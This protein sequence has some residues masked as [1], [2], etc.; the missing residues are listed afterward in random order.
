MSVIWLFLWKELKDAR[1]NPYLLPGYLVLPPIAILLPVVFTVLAPKMLQADPNDPMAKAMIKL[2]MNTPEFQGMG[3]DEAITR[4]FLRGLIVL[5][6][7]FPVGLSSIAA[8]FSIVAEK[9]QRTLE[10]ILATPIADRDF[11][12]GKLVAAVLPAIVLTWASAVLTVMMVNIVGFRLYGHMLLPD[13]FWLL[14]ILLLAPLLGIASVLV[15]MRISARVTD[16]QAANQATALVIIPVFMIGI[17]VFGKILTLSIVAVGAA[18]VVV[19]FAAALLFRWNMRSFQREE[20][21][22]RWK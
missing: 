3:Q 11:L 13:R 14:G 6:F 7:I 4:Y 22:T 1:R 16:P 5:Y 15:S 12:L 21:L 19:A 8:A 10:P 20:I 17:G 18:C 2:V 9:Q